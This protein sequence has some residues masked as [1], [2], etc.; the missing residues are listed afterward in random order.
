MRFRVLKS[1]IDR[2]RRKTNEDGVSGNVVLE[3]FLHGYLNSHPAVMAMVDQWIRDT[4]EEPPDRKHAMSRSDLREIYAAAR[5][6]IATD[7]EDR[8][9]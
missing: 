3:A 8:D 7:E 4:G 1:L 9:G 5:G 2:F 6:A